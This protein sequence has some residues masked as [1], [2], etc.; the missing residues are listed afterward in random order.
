MLKSK[1]LCERR[2]AKLFKGSVPLWSRA[3]W[4]CAS[5]LARCLKELKLLRLPV[6]A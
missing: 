3:L 2:E 6:A 1:P 4:S 5:E